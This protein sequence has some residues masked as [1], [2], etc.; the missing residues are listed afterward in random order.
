MTVYRRMGPLTLPPHSGHRL[1]ESG[2]ILI[3]GI[4]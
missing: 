1:A 2:H 3:S 4:M